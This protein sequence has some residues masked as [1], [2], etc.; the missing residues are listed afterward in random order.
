[1][2]VQVAPSNSRRIF[3][4]VDI[5]ASSDTVWEVRVRIASIV[6]SEYNTH[7]K[8]RGWWFCL[9]RL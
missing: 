6:Q 4:G 2:S 7:I 3:A 8:K 5:T 9:L 1:M